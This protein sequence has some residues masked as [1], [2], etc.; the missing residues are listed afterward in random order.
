MVYSA[1]YNSPVGCLLLEADESAVTKVHFM[2]ESHETA[3]PE[4]PILKQCIVELDEY[5]SGMRE[6]FSVPLKAMG[7]GF[8]E[9]V[10]AQLLTIPFAKTISY[11]QLAVQLGDLKSIRAAGTANGKNPLAIIIPCHRVIGSDGSLTGY[12]GGLWRKKWL[13]DFERKRKQGELF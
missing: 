9:K 6:V 12:G 13:L 5:F 4:F 10:W 3:S 7:T 1:F 11:A 8:Q 2:D